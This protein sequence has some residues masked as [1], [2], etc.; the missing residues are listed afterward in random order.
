MK[1]L[2]EIKAYLNKLTD[3]QLKVIVLY[4]VLV[5]GLIFLPLA[6]I[7]YKIIVLFTLYVSYARGQINM[8]V[9]K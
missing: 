7:G 8:I 3:A 6:N 1:K 2:N 9:K 5:F 4:H